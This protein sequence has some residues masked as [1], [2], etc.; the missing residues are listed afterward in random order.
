[1]TSANSEAARKIGQARPLWT[2]VS[3]LDRII[4]RRRVLL[5]AGPPFENR[6]DIPPLL[7]NSLAFAC[8]YEGWAKTWEEADALVL[9]ND[10]ELG[11][12]QDFA[13]LLP[14]AG[15][16]SPSMALIEVSSST[17]PAISAWSVLNEG[18]SCASRLG[19]R[20]MELPAHHAWLNG[21]F[22]DWLAAL[23][24]EPMELYP[25]LTEAIRNGDDGHAAVSAGSMAMVEALSRRTDRPIPSAIS[26]FVNTNTSFAINIWMAMAAA[27]LGQAAGTVDSTVVVQAGGNGFQYGLKLARSPKRWFKMEGPRPTGN[28]DPGR[29]ERLP[30]RGIGDSAVIDFLGLGGQLIGEKSPIFQGLRHVLPH[31]HIE[32]RHLFKCATLSGLGDLT[33]GVDAQAVV[34]SGQGP[35]VLLGMLDPEGRDGRIGGGMIEV[36]VALFARALDDAVDQTNDAENVP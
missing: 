3:R 17:A 16:A 25:L 13:V 30:A 35:V 9:S 8:V 28:L 4:G 26:T 19:L 24:T 32:R 33:G 15:V 21:P 18:G 23:F 29:Q 31:R 2:G 34:S 11:A 10:I 27:V 6:A 12:G 5:H 22:A 1:M 20:N 36:P 14:L 7:R